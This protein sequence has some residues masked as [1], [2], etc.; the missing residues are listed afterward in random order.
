MMRFQRGLYAMARSFDF[1]QDDRGWISGKQEN[2]KWISG[3]QEIRI[4]SMNRI[5]LVEAGTAGII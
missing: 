5:S 3:E 4:Y 1:A 2:R